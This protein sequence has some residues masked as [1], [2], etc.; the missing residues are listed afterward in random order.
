[1]RLPVRARPQDQVQVAGMETM[2]DPA[3]RAEQGGLLGT[4]L[5][6][7]GQPP[8]VE[9]RS[10]RLRVRR[11]AVG[12]ERL[13]GGEMFGAFIAEIGLGRAQRVEVGGELDAV[14]AVTAVTVRTAF[15]ARRGRLPWRCRGSLA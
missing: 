1:D 8:V 6:G 14:T 13:G 11:G 12:K 5:P 15:T 7:A 2:D 4:D 3:R 9:L 10:D